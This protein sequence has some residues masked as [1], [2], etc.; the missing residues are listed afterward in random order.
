MTDIPLKNI[1][2]GLIMAAGGPLSVEELFRIMQPSNEALEIKMVREIINELVQDYSG[3]SLELKEV[4]SGWR[5]QVRNELSPW[6]AKLWEERP[7]RHSR[8]FLETLALIAY[9]QPI[10]RAEIEDVRGVSV[11]TNIVKTLLEHDWVRIAGYK[12]VPGRPALYITTKKFLDYFNLKSLQELPPLIEF[13][14]S[15]EVE[16][17]I[18][19]LVSSEDD[20]AQVVVDT[21]EPIIEEEPTTQI[22]IEVEEDPCATSS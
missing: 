21:M 8:A 16:E 15:P 11:G 9:H 13:T 17:K 14:E 20:M 5:F 12:E 19:A 2:E 4:A 10:T 18:N 3:R 22:T 1:V 7:P 6:I